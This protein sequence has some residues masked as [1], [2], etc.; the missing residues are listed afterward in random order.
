M[1]SPSAI[2]SSEFPSKIWNIPW[3]LGA[4]HSLGICA[5]LT[6]TR[7]PATQKAGSSTNFKSSALTLFFLRLIVCQYF[8]QCT[9]TANENTCT[10]RTFLE[11]LG[12]TPLI[13]K[14]PSNAAVSSPFFDLM[15]DGLLKSTYI[16]TNSTSFIILNFIVTDCGVCIWPCSGLGWG[17]PSLRCLCPVIHHPRRR[18]ELH[19]L[20]ERWVLARLSNSSLDA[21]QSKY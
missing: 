8:V 17:K 2:W 10:Q 12:I 7:G 5:L 4:E 13:K 16:F 9:H 20:Q 6:R 18:S 11:K 21:L 19:S 3:R 1:F 15:H 14:I